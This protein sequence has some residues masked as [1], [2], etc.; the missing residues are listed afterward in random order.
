MIPR[1]F[2][3]AGLAIG[4]AAAGAFRAWLGRPADGVVL[5]AIAVAVACTALRIHLEEESPR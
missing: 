2:T 5:V 1:P 3:L 4:V